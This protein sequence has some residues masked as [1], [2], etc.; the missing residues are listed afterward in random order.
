MRS[1]SSSMSMVYRCPS[2]FYIE[3]SCAHPSRHA[4]CSRS[5]K[6]LALPLPQA[7]CTCNMAW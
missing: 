2:H 1:G 6:Y 4:L 3:H 5:D 7:S